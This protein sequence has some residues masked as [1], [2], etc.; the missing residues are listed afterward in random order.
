MSASQLSLK[1]RS[2]YIGG[3]RYVSMEVSEYFKQQ[4]G[5]AFFKACNRLT[6]I[7]HMCTVQER[8]NISLDPS[9]SVNF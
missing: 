6:Q 1:S 2:L 8:L 5:P 4:N 7:F 9:L 3:I